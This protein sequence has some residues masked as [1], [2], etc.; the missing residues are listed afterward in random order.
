[1]SDTTTPRADAPSAQDVHARTRVTAALLVGGIAAGPIY[2][3]VGLVQMLVRDGFDIRRHPLSLMSN[4][5]LGWIQVANFLLTGA[6]TVVAAVGMRR[7]LSPGR[8]A[9]WGP[10][11]VGVYGAGVFL[12]GLFRADPVD[13]FPPG[14]PL[15]PPEQVS[16]HG[17]V[18]FLVAGIA[19][20]ALA[21]GTFVLARRFAAN[22][23]RG[24]VAYSVATGV[25]FLAAFLGVAAG[26]AVINVVFALAIVNVC[27]WVA[28]VSALLRRRV[29]AA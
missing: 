21:A 22:R 24:W 1:M 29:T 13:G 7:A 11:L 15:G 25:V 14:T 3:A 27:A 18:H 9:M 5:D 26:S 10:L 23:Q 17:L 16:W 4:G 19:F 12:A 28:A 8:G 6:L 20:L 2:V